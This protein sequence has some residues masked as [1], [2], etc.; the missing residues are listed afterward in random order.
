MGDE[1]R[2]IRCY[3]SPA[4]A[5]RE[6]IADWYYSLSPQERADADEF[7][8]DMRKIKLWKMPQYRHLG[9]GTGLG[10]LRWRSEKKQHRLIGFFSEGTWFAVMGCTHKQRIYDPPDALTSAAVRKN[11]IEREEVSTVEYDL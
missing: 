1:L 7:I 2:P 3:V 6:K 11:Q 10:E 9:G 8:K 5:R 4:P